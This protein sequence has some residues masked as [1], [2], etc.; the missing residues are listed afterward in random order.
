M[1]LQTPIIADPAN[2]A[3]AGVWQLHRFFDR[4]PLAQKQ[5][6]NLN[7]IKSDHLKIEVNDRLAQELEFAFYEV[8]I[9]AGELG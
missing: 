8:K 5:L 3:I 4:W 6:I 9:P 2:W 1:I 7:G